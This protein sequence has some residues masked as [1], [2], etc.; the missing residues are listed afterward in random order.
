VPELIHQGPGQMK[1]SKG[2]QIKLTETP[3]RTVSRNLFRHFGY[4]RA[5][6]DDHELRRT[7][8]FNLSGIIS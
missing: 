8:A 4:R 6:S 7:D 5:R 2:G 1:R 3:G